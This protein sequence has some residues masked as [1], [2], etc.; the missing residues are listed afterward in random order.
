[1]LAFRFFLAAAACALALAAP[2]AAQQTERMH[3]ALLKALRDEDLQRQLIAS[4]S[5]D[6]KV[7]RASRRKLQGA[8]QSFR[9][10]YRLS[11]G[12]G[13]LTDDERSTLRAI[14]AQFVA[15][16]G[17]KEKYTD[18]RTGLR[19][20]LPE[21]LVGKAAQAALGADQDWAEYRAGSGALSIGPEK[22]P[23]SKQTPI[24]L[25][26]NRIMTS[27]GHVT[28]RQLLL[29]PEEFST[30]AEVAI[31]QPGKED[32]RYFS[33]SQ[34]LTDGDQVKGLWMRYN[35]QAPDWFKVSDF[36]FLLPMAEAGASD[37]E[38]AK[39]D[40]REKAWT[41]LMQGVTNLVASDFPFD[42]G[43]KKVSSKAC[44]L[45]EDMAGGAAGSKSVRRILF[46]TDRVM[47]PAAPK[48][49]ETAKQVD[50]GA[51]FG[52]APDHRLRMGCAYVSLPVEGGDASTPIVRYHLF[53]E[54]KAGDL[55]AQTY[56]TDEIGQER[57][58]GGPWIGGDALVFIHGYRVAF[59][60]ALYA[61]AKIVA[62][63][64]YQGR[65]Y[66]YSWPSHETLLGYFQDM[67]NAEQAE[68]YFESFMRMLMR[69]AH[70]NEIDLI[71]HSMGSQ[72]MLRAVSALRPLFDMERGEAG[73]DKWGA[74]PSIRVGQMIFAAPDVARS[75][76]DEKI[77]RIAP[78]A[79]RITVYVSST[80]VALSLA[81]WIRGGLPRMGELGPPD[82]QP[83]LIDNAKVH[84]ID[85]TPSQSFLQRLSGFGHDYLIQAPGVSDDMK[86][87]L[88]GRGRADTQTPDE[89]N[90]TRFVKKRYLGTTDKYYWQ[91]RPA[92]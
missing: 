18:P 71:A 35:I 56:L 32:F 19:I 67:D 22:I 15:A 85:V 47:L 79:D 53:H 6:A 46:A 62:D 37:P 68:P 61:V 1:M 73:L 59:K 41:L 77:G 33:Y 91:L 31:P 44:P 58:R 3:P 20:L 5:L 11:S 83:A 30:T 28:Y 12:L 88:T 84:I 27:P 89:R 36:E 52:N 86:A 60:D 29:T 90:K 26:R 51:L 16:T 78:F 70:I 66:L 8:I 43:A 25:F 17:L 23:L 76:F 7:G 4:G 87:I 24:S 54:G 2:A 50:P 49:G 34:V 10:A 65:V 42:N 21:R 82:N 48:P 55:G 57:T 38:T 13:P 40:T 9:K 74:N 72:S 80:D 75:V 64:G 69:D 39:A 63:T 81:K 92:P 45:S 14:Y